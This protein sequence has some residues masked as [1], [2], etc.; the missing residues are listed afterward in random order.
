MAEF[1]NVNVAGPFN[2]FYEQGE[3]YRVRVEGTADQLG[4]MT[5]YVKNG[6]LYIDQRK[7][8]PSGT[9]DG[10]QV[11]VTSPMVE[12]FEIAG[13][14]S[15]T[16]PKA[17]TVND[18]RLEIAGSGDIT[19]AQLTSKDLYMEI[20]GSGDIALGTVQAN[21]VRSEIAGSG[22]SGNISLNNLNVDHVKSEIAGSGNVIL[23]GKV[24]SH[25]EEIAGSGKVNVSGLTN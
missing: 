7:Q 2:V 19:L 23:R 9:F 4:K 25:D 3:N 15:I 14:G 11:F 5:I 18:I 16:A 8:E 24:G 12:A 20:A 6:D 22:G 13:S 17:L 1:D 10:L 21:E